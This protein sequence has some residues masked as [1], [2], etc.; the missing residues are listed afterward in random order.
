MKAS[1]MRLSSLVFAV[2]M[3]V[4]GSSL[5]HA[6]KPEFLSDLHEFRL[7][8]FLALNAYYRYSDSRDRALQQ[9]INTSI[10]NASRAMSAV[11]NSDTNLLAGD[12][13][14]RLNQE[15]DK[16]RALMQQNIEDV[17]TMG[18]PD[19]RLLSEMAEQAHELN[20]IS[21]ELYDIAREKSDLDIDDR[22]ESIRAASVLIAQMLSNYTA[23]STSSVQQT[24][25]GATT[26]VP[27]DELARRF[28]ALIARIG[29]EGTEEDMRDL[30]H[31]ADSKWSFIRNSYINFNENNV[32]FV[33]DRYSKGIIDSLERM[34]RVIESA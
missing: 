4:L 26:G 24:F 3:M 33:I 19:L 16:F 25:Q 27:L 22:V 21:T 6:E 15:F 23:R 12:D 1:G 17:R 14:S 20:Q 28:D 30:L 10:N 11:R 7:H 8:N 13:I 18:Y 31:D 34:I 5:A 29:A 2:A 9:D 32:V